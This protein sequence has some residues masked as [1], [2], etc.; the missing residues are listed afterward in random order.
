MGVKPFF[1]SS[2]FDSFMFSS[3]P[4]AILK[5]NTNISKSY[6]QNSINIYLNAGYVPAPFSI[7]KDLKQIPAGCFLNWTGNGIKIKKW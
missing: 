4:Q 2:G 3:R 5:L 7:Y 6:D 1:Y